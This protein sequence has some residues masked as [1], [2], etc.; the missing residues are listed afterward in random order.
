MTAK[1]HT[2]TVRKYKQTLCCSYF[3]ENFSSKVLQGRLPENLLK[4]STYINI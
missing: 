2:V 4:N 1:L 3:Y